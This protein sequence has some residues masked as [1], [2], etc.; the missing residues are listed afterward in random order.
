ML[1]PCAL[2][3]TSPRRRSVS[4]ARLSLKSS[5]S[6][7]LRSSAVD[8]VEVCMS[9]VV[10]MKSTL[11]ICGLNFAA[12]QSHRLENSLETECRILIGLFWRKVFLF[13]LLPSS[14]SL[15]F[16]HKTLSR[17]SVGSHER[18]EPAVSGTLLQASRGKIVPRIDTDLLWT[19]RH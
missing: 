5:R 15:L 13:R 18:P 6:S 11:E 16:R 3:R 10:A 19:C 1:I 8:G 7:A 14:L 17:A 12:R 2:K 4:I 9:R